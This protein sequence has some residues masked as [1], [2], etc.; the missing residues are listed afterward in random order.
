M[1]LDEISLL[2]RWKEDCYFRMVPKVLSSAR[3]ADP[4]NHTW[5]IQD[6]APREAA[7]SNARQPGLGSVMCLLPWLGSEDVFENL[8]KNTSFSP[9]LLLLSPADQAARAS[10]SIA[11]VGN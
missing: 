2:C 5:A 6:V 8:C 4:Q 9:S 3:N 11:G 7:G 10:H 1:V